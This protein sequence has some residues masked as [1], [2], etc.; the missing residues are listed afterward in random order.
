MTS[1]PV[2]Y[3]FMKSANSFSASLLRLRKAFC[4]IVKANSRPSWS[5]NLYGEFSE[6]KVLSISGL[7]SSIQMVL[8]LSKACLASALLGAV[9]MIFLYSAIA[10]S[11][12]PVL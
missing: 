12:R 6:A 1:L 4:A 10:A 8:I 11:D 5:L 3:F 7:P 9:V 2:R